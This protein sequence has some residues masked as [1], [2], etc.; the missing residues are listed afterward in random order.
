MA[1]DVAG[2]TGASFI[3][4]AGGQLT[5]VAT[6]S[7]NQ[8]EDVRESAAVT[9]SPA[10]EAPRVMEAR[11]SPEGGEV[12]QDFT[13]VVAAAGVPS[14]ALVVPVVARRRRDRRGDRGLPY[15]HGGRPAVGDGHR[16]EPGRLRQRR[17]RACRRR[18]ARVAPVV[19]SVS[20]S[21]PSGQVGDVFTA[22]AL[23]SGEPVPT[24]SYQWLLDGAA[25]PG[26]TTASFVADAEGELSVV[27]TAD[28]SGRLRQ[29]GERGGQRRAG[30]GRAS[31]LQR[32]DLAG[33]GTGR[34]CVQRH[35]RRERNAR[36]GPDVS[37]VSGW[38]GDRRRD[39]RNLRRGSDRRAVGGSHRRQFGRQREPC[40][41][42][43]VGA[44]GARRP[45]QPGASRNRGHRAGRT[46]ADRR[47]RRR[48]VG[49]ARA[50]TDA[51][52]AAQ[53]RRDRGGDRDHLRGAGL[54][55]RHARS[56]CG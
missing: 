36:A 6:A 11:V 35:R 39:G 54:R 53:W 21:P 9:V 26:A 18:Y 1:L 5:V 32:G 48:L 27:V 55:R 56:R 31:D 17:E 29:P 43:C 33:V 42:S 50:V 34:R 41:R 15:R 51:T 8:G 46:D 44:G 28:E 52:V 13:A 10:L 3:A 25:I 7:N 16:D 23:A 20:V 37:V 47:E 38:G 30:P 12:G 22:T 19:E 2:A 24:L 14:P 4:S 45:G 49:Q 40:E